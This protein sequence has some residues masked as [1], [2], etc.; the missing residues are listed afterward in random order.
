MKGPGI[1][2]PALAGM[3]F[4]VLRLK[5]VIYLINSLGEKLEST[6]NTKKKMNALEILLRIIFYIFIVYPF[7]L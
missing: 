2:S 7:R 6:Y 3:M 4:Q 5:K 1:H